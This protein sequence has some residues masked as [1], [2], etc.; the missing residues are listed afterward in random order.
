M[1][2]FDLLFTTVAYAEE[3]VETGQ[4]SAGYGMG[5]SILMLVVMFALLYFMLIRPQKK[6]D[7]E[8]K[9]MIDALKVGDKVVT[10]G[11]ICGKITK[12]KDDFVIIESGNVGT[13]SEKS[14]I[15]M[16]RDSIK[17]VENKQTV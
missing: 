5:G 16:E 4:L 9:A 10:I 6:R 7:K 17:S 13:P 1:N 14:Y 2:I 3:G 8:T 11:G 12:I 15:K